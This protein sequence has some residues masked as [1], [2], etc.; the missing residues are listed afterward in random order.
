MYHYIEENEGWH[1]CDCGRLVHRVVVGFGP[2]TH[3]ITVDQD[4]G[5]LCE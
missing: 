4:G 5:E 2:Q 1:Y 3:I